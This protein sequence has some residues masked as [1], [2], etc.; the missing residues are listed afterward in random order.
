MT[1]DRLF[2]I[3]SIVPAASAVTGISVEDLLPGLPDETRNIVLGLWLQKLVERGD[4]AV[5]T[6]PALWCTHAQAGALPFAVE[7]ALEER[8]RRFGTAVLRVMRAAVQR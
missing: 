2:S 5:T 6:G 4:A 1:T 7:F 8:W 3:A